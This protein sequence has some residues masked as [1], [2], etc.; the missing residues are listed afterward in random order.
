MIPEK[1]KKNHEILLYG[2]SVAVLFL[3]LRFLEFRFL[4]ISHRFELYVGGIAIVFTLVGIAF[5]KKWSN[6]KIKI[7]TIVVQND[8]ATPDFLPNHQEIAERK[9]SNREIEVLQLIAEG[10]SNKEIA[11]A[12]FVSLNTIK[13]HS[14]NIFEKLEA[15]RRTQAV[16]KAKKLRI[17]S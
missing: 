2:I 14:S 11:D 13:T 9:I 1:I 4:I 12:L 8:S 15:K 3:L 6:P 10:K 17:I 7:Q 16:E 5:A